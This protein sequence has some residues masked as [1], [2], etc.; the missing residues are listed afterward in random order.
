M[1]RHEKEISR[2][3]SVKKNFWIL[4]KRKITFFSLENIKKNSFVRF[5]KKK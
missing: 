3:E 4:K 5:L 1:K 2:S